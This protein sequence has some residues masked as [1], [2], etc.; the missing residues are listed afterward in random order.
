METNEEYTPLFEA[1]LVRV[2]PLKSPAGK[3]YYIPFRYGM[4]N[5]VVEMETPKQLSVRIHCDWLNKCRTCEF[6]GDNREDV[7]SKSNCKNEK[8]PLFGELTTSDGYCSEWD[9]YDYETAL[10]M[11]DEKC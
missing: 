6:W 9:S 10:E 3:L 8:S 2:E 4:R 7:L 5:E 11:F 1:T